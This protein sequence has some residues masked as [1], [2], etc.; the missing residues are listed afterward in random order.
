MLS[1]FGLVPKGHAFDIPNGVLGMLFY[2]Y[3]FL[4]SVDKY[5]R[6]MSILFTSTFNL[7]ISS[8]AISSSV[9]LGRKLYI[10]QELC[11]VCVSTHIINTT[12]WIRAIREA[13][14]S[15]QKTEKIL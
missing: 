15:S 13:F 10:I 7:I 11:I 14:G 8:L 1:F 5:P 6:G 12:A 3:V 9:F 4:R 2:T